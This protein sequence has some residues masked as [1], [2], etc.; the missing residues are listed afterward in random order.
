MF[1]FTKEQSD[2]GIDFE[3]MFI[4]EENGFIKSYFYYKP[5][6]RHEYQNPHEASS[7]SRTFPNSLV[8]VYVCI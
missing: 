4:Y 8:Y 7:R 1:S 3:N 2:I 5:K 6:D